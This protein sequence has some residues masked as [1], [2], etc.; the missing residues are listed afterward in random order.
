MAQSPTFASRLKRKLLNGPIFGGA[1]K[2]IYGSQIH[3]DQKTGKYFVAPIEDE[4]N[5]N[6][7]RAAV[8]LEPLEEY[9]K[10]WNIDYKLPMK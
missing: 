8:G 2:Q 6:K 1:Y 5:V 4:Q 10:Q 3:R 9:A 7:R